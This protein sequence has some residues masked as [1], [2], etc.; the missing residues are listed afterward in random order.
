MDALPLPTD[1]TVSNPGLAIGSPLFVAIRATGNRCQHYVLQRMVSNCVTCLRVA[2]EIFKQSSL[3]AAKREE[4][5]QCYKL[6]YVTD[7]KY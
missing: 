3:L 6:D 4:L 2:M 1:H 7:F 5:T